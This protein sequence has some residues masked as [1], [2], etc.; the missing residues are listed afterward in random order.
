MRFRVVHDVMDPLNT[1]PEAALAWIARAEPLRFRRAMRE[2]AE[3]VE[4]IACVADALERDHPDLCARIV[5]SSRRR[6]GFESFIG[7]TGDEPHL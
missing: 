2:M 7:S 6:E 1:E 4:T 3:A 5:E